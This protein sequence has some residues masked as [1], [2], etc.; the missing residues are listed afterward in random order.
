MKKQLLFVC[1]FKIEIGTKKFSNLILCPNFCNIKD[2]LPLKNNTIDI[3]S[4]N[5]SEFEK[6]A[7]TGEISA[8]M[9]KS[10]GLKYCIVGNSERK[11]FNFETLSQTNEKIKR[12]LENDII[13]IIC[14]GE[15][16]VTRNSS[17]SQTDYAKK[18][19]V[20]ELKELLKDIDVNK[21]IVA[22]EPVWAIG[23]GQVPTNEH[24]ENVLKEIKNFADI[25]TTLYGGSFNEKNFEDISQIDS[26]DGALIG[27]ASLEPKKIVYM[28][29]TLN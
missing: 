15:E 22:Y 26:V 28:L 12:L 23:S 27:G 16:I 13:P 4:Q 2:F 19:V 6:G 18:F 24:I 7:H 11:H 14:V 9:L 10:I 21:V 1:N 25:K 8:N 29:K 3:G 17:L 5:V 20:S